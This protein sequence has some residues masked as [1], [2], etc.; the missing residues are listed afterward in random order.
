[1]EKEKNQNDLGSWQICANWCKFSDVK[2]TILGSK[3]DEA[4]EI[5]VN[6]FRK[7]KKL[8]NLSSFLRRI[9]ND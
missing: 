7:G 8:G 5:C 9:E 2:Y 1:M 4:E 6:L 3:Q